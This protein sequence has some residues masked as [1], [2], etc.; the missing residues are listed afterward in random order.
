MH[1]GSL[2]LLACPACKGSLDLAGE[3]GDLCTGTLSCSTCNKAYL[4][5]DGVPRFVR[6]DELTGQ[7]R[8]FAGLYNWFSFV[9]A[10]Y[11]RIAFAFIGGE[12]R[13]RNDVLGRIEPK[14]GR[15]LEVSIGPGVNL[16]YL[17]AWPGQRELF[18][19]DISPGQACAA[20]TAGQSTCSWAMPKSCLS[21]IGCLTPS[22]TSEASTSSTIRRRP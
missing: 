10:L 17:K 4:I 9:Y 22:F 12:A 11:S 16:P 14:A 18:G 15:I 3:V 19:L 21:R 2:N 5:V 20:T 7:N 13:N 6:A 1:R 8:R